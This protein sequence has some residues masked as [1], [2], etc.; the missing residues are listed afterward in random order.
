MVMHFLEMENISKKILDEL[1]KYR[2]YFTDS[3]QF[4]D[5]EMVSKVQLPRIRAFVEQG[6]KLYLFYLHF[7]LN[8]L[9]QRKL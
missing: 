7:L 3:I 6:R 4:I 2:R 9:T 5:E 1:L 8:R